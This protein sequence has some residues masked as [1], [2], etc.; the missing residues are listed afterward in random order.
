MAI[1]GDAL[2]HVKART[3]SNE[4]ELASSLLARAREMVPL[5]AKRAAQAEQRVSRLVGQSSE[6]SSH[7]VQHGMWIPGWPTA[8]FAMVA[9]VSRRW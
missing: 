5:L 7:D 3:E 4:A 6:G 9:A 8:Q 2:H 1:S